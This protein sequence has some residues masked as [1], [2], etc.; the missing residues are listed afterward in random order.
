MIA[1]EPRFFA[2]LRHSAMINFSALAR[3]STRCGIRR[4]TGAF[5]SAAFP[6]KV[7]AQSANLSGDK[8]FLIPHQ[9]SAGAKELQ[10]RPRCD[11]ELL[12]NFSCGQNV[13]LVLKPPGNSSSPFLTTQ[14]GPAQLLVL[15]PFA[16]FLAGRR[17]Y[18]LGVALGAGQSI[19]GGLKRG[20]TL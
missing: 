19:R 6:I 16:H 1:D 13:S 9:R 2:H 11:K 3:G 12:D 14:D 15:S 20:G 17:A 10:Q 8:V 7:Y 4:P 5:L 18:V